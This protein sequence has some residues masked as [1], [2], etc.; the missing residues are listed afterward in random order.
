MGRGER[1]GN[2]K[3]GSIQNYC[4]VSPYV[5][6]LMLFLAERMPM[7]NAWRLSSIVVHVGYYRIDSYSDPFACHCIRLYLT[8]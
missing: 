3:S 1:A 4:R 7:P 5:H 8:Y 6:I 2:E